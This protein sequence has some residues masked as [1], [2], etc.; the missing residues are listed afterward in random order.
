MLVLTR[1]KNEQLVIR[2]GTETVTVRILDVVHGR[3]RVGI[4]APKSVAIHREEVARRIHE[5]N[6]EF[7]E[8]ITDPMPAS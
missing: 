8:L 4:V 7:E 2:L 3:V 5:L 6:Y 1:K